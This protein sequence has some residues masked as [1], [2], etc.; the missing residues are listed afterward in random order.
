MNEFD[1]LILAGG[2]SSRFKKKKP[3]LLFKIKN[4]K[5]IDHSINLARKIKP[6][7]IFVI[8]NNR[9]NFLKRKNKD[10]VFLIQ[11]KPLGTGHA[12]RIYLKHKKRTD[13]LLVLL[14]DTP[15]IRLE[16][17]NKIIKKMYLNDLVVF[18]FKSKKNHSYGLIKID[19]HNNVLKIIE[20]KNATKAEKKIYLCNSGIMGIN[21]KKLNLINKIKKDTNTKEYLLTNIVEIMKREN[22][23]ISCVISNR[24]LSN[25]GINTYKEYSYLKKL[26]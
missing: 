14:G 12:V 4:K 16:D 17:I 15:F 21:K 5:L 10:C 26:N 18:G 1:I 23:K 9:L 13:N 3:K 20:Y 24:S 11:K 6:R 22:R 2:K 25:R 7:K 8:I 19:K